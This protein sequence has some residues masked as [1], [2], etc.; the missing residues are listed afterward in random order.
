[1][2]VGSNARILL[3]GATGHTGSR[4]ARRLVAD[5]Y[6]LRVLSRSADRVREVLGDLSID[7][8]VESDLDR[9]DT[10]SE[11]ARDCAAVISLAHI[12]FA[13]TVI[14]MCRAASVSRVIF[15]SSTRRYT[16]FPDEPAD[17]VREAEGIIRASD[18]DY[19]ILRPTMIFGGANDGNL[20]SVVRL[21][22][23]TPIIPLP[24]GGRNLV[25]PTYTHDLIKAIMS[26]LASDDLPYREYDLGG[27]E[28]MTS[29]AMIHTIAQAVGRRVWI[30][31]VP[32]WFARL[33][34]RMLASVS[35]RYAMTVSQVDR[36]AEDKVVDIPPARRDLG[37]R[38]T[39]FAEA[40]ADKFA[41]RA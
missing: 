35:G 32:L 19:T 28:A 37:Y 15:I 17:W 41:G 5:G 24:G 9:P 27:A 26:A 14:E 6:R 11:A 16:R 31:P 22:R 13:P 1:M 8:I 18:L 39:P 21:I 38:P 2:S 36:Q 29:R 3:T 30:A 33:V 12:R 20:E 7:D 40:I 4:L 34:A 10:A 25:Q 23:R